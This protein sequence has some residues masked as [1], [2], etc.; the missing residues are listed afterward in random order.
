[1][2]PLPP[3]EERRKVEERCLWCFA[4]SNEASAGTIVNESATG[5]LLETEDAIQLGKRIW[6]LILPGENPV[7][8]GISPENLINHP[9]TR[10]GMAIRQETETRIGIQFDQEDTERPHYQRYYRGTS[11]ITTFIDKEKAAV[12]LRGSLNF[13]T[14]VLMERIFTKQFANCKDILFSCHELQEIN[15]PAMT[16]LRTAIRLCDRNGITVTIITG[17]ETAETVEKHLTLQNGFLVNIDSNESEGEKVSSDPIHSQER[18]YPDGAIIAA[19]GNATLN[20][21]ATPLDRVDVFSWKT[22]NFKELPDL[23]INQNPRFVV[24]EVEIEHCP[25]LVEINRIKKL[26]P[27][28]MPPALVI[29]PPHLGELIREALALPVKIYKIKPC[30]DREYAKSIHAMLSEEY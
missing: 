30:T 1:M 24:I 8:Q 22:Q 9:L 15:G 28:H 20:R 16:V 2:A 13:D 6:I 7:P 17:V 25:S 4:E 3:R 19:R 14:A 29:G 23:I 27:D 18:T 5:V 12:T 21:L 11:S 26:K 10:A